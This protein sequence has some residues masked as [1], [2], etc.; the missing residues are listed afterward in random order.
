MDKGSLAIAL[1]TVGA[2]TYQP[3]RSSAAG[4]ESQADVERLTGKEDPAA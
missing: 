2:V 3:R 4:L 1:G